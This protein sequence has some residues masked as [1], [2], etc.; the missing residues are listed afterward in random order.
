MYNIYISN[1]RDQVEEKELKKGG[2]G[3]GM[4]IT[5]VRLMGCTRVHY[6]CE[7]NESYPSR[8]QVNGH[9]SSPYL[10]IVQ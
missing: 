6:V 8:I 3:N 1:L 2:G 7:L 9:N 5:C 10:Y 4:K